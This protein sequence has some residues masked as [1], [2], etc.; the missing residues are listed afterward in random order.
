[1]VI[2]AN[3]SW[4]DLAIPP[5]ELLQEEIEARGMTQQEL[6]ARTGRPPQAINEII[7]GKKAITNETALQLEKVLAIPAH[8]WMNLEASYQMTLA[9]LQEH[10]EL[11]EQAEALKRFPARAMEERGW[12][13]RQK[14][15]ADKV[16]ALL[17]FFGVASL[18]D[19][20]AESVTGFRI[21][22]GGNVSR[23]ALAVWLR[24]GELE[25]RGMDANPYNA[26]RFL[27]ALEEIRESTNDGPETF[28]PILK[29]LCAEGGVVVACVPEFPRSG[30]NGVARWLT[31]EKALIQLSLKWRWADVF[32]FSFFHEACHVL[33]HGRK[34]V[35]LHGIGESTPQAEAEAEADTFARD[36]LIPPNQWTRFTE[37]SDFGAPSVLGFANEVG[38]APGIVVGRMHHERIVPYNRLSTFKQRFAWGTGN[39]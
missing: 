13:L 14:E 11:T 10:R 35:Y 38:I 12:I 33:R 36:F 7:R 6:A 19:A 31:P 16:R 21:T 2:D 17:E 24:K 26:D 4:S 1:M 34:Q 28:I 3:Q 32:W 8:I 22:G 25:G 5:G 9:R 15:T 39:E 20:M 30:A 18:H 27:G 23:E 37:Q 29:Q